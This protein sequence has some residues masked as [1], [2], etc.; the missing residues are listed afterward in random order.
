MFSDFTLDDKPALSEE[1]F[2]KW[3]TF[4]KDMLHTSL[5]ISR[6]CA[7]LLSN[8]RITDDGEEAEV[9]CRGHPMAHTKDVENVEAT[10]GE[11]AMNEDYEN[12]I[13]VGVWLAVKENGEVLQRLIKWS[14]L[15][16]DAED[17]TKFLVEEDIHYLSGCFL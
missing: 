5:E 10:A 16:T 11:E 8:N 17:Q 9:D 6:V 12:L 2:L 1:R 3:R 4:Y 7:N 13:L 15:P 14:D